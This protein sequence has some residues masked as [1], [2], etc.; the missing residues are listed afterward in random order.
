MK[1]KQIMKYITIFSIL[2][3]SSPVSSWAVDTTTKRTD[4][5]TIESSKTQETNSS[6][7]STETSQNTSSDHTTFDSAS[8]EKT[9]ETNSLDNN[10]SNKSNANAVISKDSTENSA[11]KSSKSIIN[12]ND[13]QCQIST[14]GNLIFINKYL[15][16]STDIVI[17]DKIPSYE[18]IPIA[19]NFANF[20]CNIGANKITSISFDNTDSSLVSVY[21]VVDF[22]NY[23][24]LKSFNTQGS[25][26]SMIDSLTINYAFQGLKNLTSVDLSA[27]NT[28][29]VDKMEYLFD[30]CSSLTNVNLSGL[31][32]TSNVVNMSRMFNG[33]SSLK[34]ADFVKY[35]D[36]SNANDLAYMFA[37]C[38]S[39][40]KLDVT[41]FN[42]SNVTNMQNMFGNCKGLTSLDVS[43]FNTSNVTNMAYMF[44]NLKLPSLDV[45][46][47]NTSNVQ[48]MQYM[49]NGCSNL[50]NLDIRNFD[51]SNVKN[52]QN[53]F[54]GCTGLKSLDVSK[55]KTQNVE[56][57]GSM[58]SGLNVSALDVSGFN[59]TKVKNMNKMF[60][61]CSKLTNLNLKNFT[62]NSVTNM[63]YMFNNC[64]SLP[65][66]MDLS[67][68]NTSGASIGM[69]FYSSKPMPLFVLTDDEKL[70]GYDY[71]SSNRLIG[72]PV[73]N[74]NGG[75]FDNQK[76]T[77]TYFDSCAV[78]PTDPKLKLNTFQKFKKE[79]KP[80]P[81]KNSYL[82]ESWQLI[83]GIEPMKDS[84]L[85]NSVTYTAQ[86]TPSLENGNIPSQDVDNVKPGTSS[87]FGIAY[88]PKKIIVQSTQLGDG[89]F[90][91]IP[92]QP[93]KDY[94]VAVRD[95][96]M[97]TS[98][99]RLE[100]QL[101][102]D[103]NKLPNSSIQTTNSFGEVKKNINT[104]TNSFQSSDFTDN[105]G[106]VEGEPNAVINSSAPS[107]IMSSYNSQIPHNGVY[108]YELGNLSLNL[109]SPRTIPP[110]NYTGNINWTLVS[111]P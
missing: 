110:G 31:F 109:T 72:G 25:Q 58:F 16:S 5:K 10:N 8:M 38:S 80:T 48:F 95:Q 111:A 19:I 102:W 53:M 32:T 76:S 77:K 69:M 85:F 55:M 7:A 61:N 74:G 71:A 106:S 96:R 15:G 30:G 14:F 23:T 91:S 63:E 92:I 87:I 22:R 103:G 35:I 43:S 50:T 66:V 51:T 1:K 89:Y 84:D 98:D 57:M 45:S 46:R 70:K 2:C 104:G 39:L 40:T 47:F 28:S 9:E 6:R 18:N 62:T 60:N 4:G 13:F 82:F 44:N 99:W 78:S 34:N 12:Y 100:A 33:C 101:I 41:H 90:Q 97:T 68:F 54:S 67:S 79:L 105:D 73:F 29:G 36:T 24:S 42:T 21:G 56:N 81:K 86:W 49:F 108:D 83:N 17:P 37:G 93:T 65:L 59:T 75:T 64:T 107:L 11:Q 26:R 27:W 52:M 88:M 20:S 94:H 3:L